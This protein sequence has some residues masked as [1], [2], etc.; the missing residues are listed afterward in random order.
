MATLHSIPKSDERPVIR[1]TTDLADVVDAALAALAADEDVYQRDGRLVHVVRVTEAEADESA[2]AGTPQIRTMVPATLRERLTRQALFQKLDKRSGKMV[3]ALPTDPV[4]Q[5]ALARGEYPGIRPIVG[6][7]ESPSIR[8]DGSIIQ[9]PG[10]DRVTGYLF[11]PNVA[12]PIVPERPTKEDAARAL[13]ELEETFQDFPFATPEHRASTIA[14]LLT[15]L[16]RPAIAGSTPAIL[17]DANTRGSGKTLKADA[18]ATI[19]TGRATAKMSYPAEDE[20]LEK[21]LAAYA[22]RGAALISFDNITSTFGGGPLDRCLTAGDTV[23]LRVLGKSEVPSL[24]WRAVIM[25]T[26]NNIAIAGDTSRRVLISRLESPL[27]NPEERQEFAHHPLLPWVQ[28]NRP[29]LVVAA[30]TVLRAWFVAGKPKVGCKSWGSFE[31]WSAMVPPAIVFAGGADPMATR[32]AA[33]GEEDGEKRALVA[34][35]DGLVRLD[36]VGRGLSARQVIDALYP[37]ERL[38]GHAPPDG[39]ESLR[40]AIDAL[41]ANQPGRAPSSQKL[42]TKLHRFKRRVVAGRMLDCNLDSHTKVARWAVVAGSAGSAGTVPTPRVENGDNFMDTGDEAT[43]DYSQSPQEG[44][45]DY[46]E[47]EGIGGA[48]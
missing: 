39:F 25:A 44:F 38:R 34:I 20:E 16:G 43:R 19:A 10:Y 2:I 3:A 28:L 23:E 33:T 13:A 18:V 4:V 26:G 24:R 8:P 41:V 5:A 29:R 36:T 40:E 30:L 48:Q 1:L 17:H 11:A 42:G 27:E 31:A 37:A 46:L 22:L 7:I 35:L 21:V 12:F 15:V 32:P 6:V 45:S 9:T 47:R 14:A